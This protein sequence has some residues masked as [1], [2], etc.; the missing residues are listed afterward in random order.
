MID[1]ASPSLPPLPERSHTL[2]LSVSLS[3]QP[4]PRKTQPAHADLQVSEQQ[5]KCS[6]KDNR[7]DNY[8]KQDQWHARR[9]FCGPDASCNQGWEDCLAWHGDCQ[10]IL[11]SF[12]P[13]TFRLPAA[14]QPAR[15]VVVWCGNTSAFATGMWLSVPLSSCWCP[16]TSGELG[17][18]GGGQWF[19]QIWQG[20]RAA[21][22]FACG[23]GRH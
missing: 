7:L 22:R 20:W 21:V 1:T 10:S 13:S 2:C 14:S 6:I 8:P 3:V 19:V 5:Q 17:S 12:L 23:R 4:H 11:W 9:G 18:Q 15:V 16:S